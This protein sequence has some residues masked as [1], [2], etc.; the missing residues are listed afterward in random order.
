MAL[1][2][3]TVLLVTMSGMASASAS[4]TDILPV[5]DQCV[6][7]IQVISV[8][9]EKVGDITQE[10]IGAPPN[11]IEINTSNWG[12][13]LN[14]SEK[15]IFEPCDKIQFNMYVQIYEDSYV[16][17]LQPLV[18]NEEGILVY[19]N[20]WKP[21]YCEAGLWVFYTHTYIPCYTSP[22]NLSWAALIATKDG[23]DCECNEKFSIV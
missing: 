5:S 6:I 16:T 8:Q 9:S 18:F 14:V 13:P 17:V 12:N 19:G 2:V 23:Q 4:A 21:V 20:K 1:A 3:C 22:Q 10:D 15:A 11:I 7:D